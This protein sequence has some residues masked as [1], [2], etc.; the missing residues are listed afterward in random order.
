MASE[1]NS[2]CVP[3]S[4]PFGPQFDSLHIGRRTTLSLHPDQ[5]PLLWPQLSS[6]QARLFNLVHETEA[7]Y[8]LNIFWYVVSTCVCFKLYQPHWVAK[9]YFVIW[10]VA[11]PV[12]MDHKNRFSLDRLNN[13]LNCSDAPHVF[14][15][16]D[17]N[18]TA[19]FKVSI[20]TSSQPFSVLLILVLP[21]LLQDFIF[22]VCHQLFNNLVYGKTT[23]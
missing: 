8:R 23:L 4:L 2:G 14:L 6:F 11:F 13:K 19:N 16:S 22:A 15:I 18:F 1:W 7:I 3:I 21:F 17:V 5:M 9:N 12:V 20:K 10:A